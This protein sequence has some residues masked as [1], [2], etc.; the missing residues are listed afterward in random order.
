MKNALMLPVLCTALAGCSWFAPTAY[1]GILIQPPV[2]SATLAIAGDV[3]TLD[4]QYLPR[5][6]IAPV[7]DTFKVKLNDSYTLK[8][9]RADKGSLEFRL[10]DNGVAVCDGCKNLYAGNLSALAPQFWHAKDGIRI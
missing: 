10:D 5:T 7:H 2:K 3:A 9:V 4:I 1:E 6:N 8:L